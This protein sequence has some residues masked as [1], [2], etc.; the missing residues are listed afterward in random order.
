MKKKKSYLG[1]KRIFDFLF[2]FLTIVLLLPILLFL[3][4]II[5]IVMHGNPFFLQNRPGKN[6]KIFRMIKFRTMTNKK[7]ENGV[8]LSDAERLTKFGRFLRASSIDELPELFNVLKGDMSLIGPRPFLVEYLPLYNDFQKRR[9]EVLPG[10]T[11]WA[12]V[13]GRNAI[14]W[15][16]K[17]KYDVEYVDNVSFKLD[18]KIF[19]MTIGKVFKRS[20]IQHGDDATMP[21][22]KGEENEQNNT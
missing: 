4:I 7:D 18:I 5:S 20:G 11:G 13:N 10:I 17:F 2:S 3:I 16:E 8:L 1:F 9:H 22:F 19:F 12:Q 15:T 21:D 6:G 14:N